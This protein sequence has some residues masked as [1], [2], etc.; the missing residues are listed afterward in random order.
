MSV[1]GRMIGTACVAAGVL[2]IVGHF[3]GLVSDLLAR[4]ASFTPVLILMPIAGVIV[5]AVVRSWWLLSVGVVVLLAGVSTQLPLYRGVDEVARPSDTT[6]MQAN[7]YLG[8]A[9]A[10]KLVDQVRSRNADILTVVELTPEAVGH[11]DAAGLRAV[12]P[13]GFES[14]RSG[15]GGT[16]IYSRYPLTDEELMPGFTH[17]NLRAVADVPGLGRTA[18]F[19][20]HPVPPYPGP[21]W[22]WDAEMR[23]LGAVLAAERL[24]VIVSGDFNSTF[25]HRQFRD[26]LAGSN[27]ADSPELTSVAKYLGAGV[28][29]T[30]PADRRF[31][32]VLAID[33]ILTRGGWVP[34]SFHRFDIAGSDHHGVVATIAPR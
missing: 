9:D 16:G 23:R 8:R 31:G 26:L 12:L 15:G 6:V 1:V 13:F 7:I 25:D 19:A 28:V 30:Y 11:L 24:P 10:A 4:V 27:T 22:Q 3:S 2:G 29:P 5:F 33:H 18:V 20:V 34:T 14:A 21:A 17:S 32:A